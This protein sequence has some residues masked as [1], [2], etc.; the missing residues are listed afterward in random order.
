MCRTAQNDRACTNA[1][2][3]RLRLKVLTG[4]YEEGP[5]WESCASV[6]LEFMFWGEGEIGNGRLRTQP[7]QAGIT[8]FTSCMCGRFYLYRSSR[9]HLVFLQHLPFIFTASSIHPFAY[10][11]QRYN[12]TSFL[13]IFLSHTT[14][15]TG[16]SIFPIYHCSGSQGVSEFSAFC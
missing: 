8:S 11:V 2:A 6:G 13:Y 1:D 9:S 4:A 12:T 15:G 5:K 16:I 10:I 3:S 14:K 7:I